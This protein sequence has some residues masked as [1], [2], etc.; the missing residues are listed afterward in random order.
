MRSIS[1]TYR[2][3]AETRNRDHRAPTESSDLLAVLDELNLD[4][5]SDSGVGLLGLNT[6]LL[7][8]DTLGVRST[9]ER[10]RLV[11]GTEETLFVVQIGPAVLTTSSRE[12]AGGV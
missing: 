12:L 4:T 2:E 3:Y 10:R 11:S 5:L 1:L 6:D 9:T 8:D 7:K